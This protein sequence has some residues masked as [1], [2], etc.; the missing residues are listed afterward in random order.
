MSTVTALPL[1]GPTPHGA[2]SSRSAR[3]HNDPPAT[4]FAGPEN[5]L[6]VRAIT[7]LLEAAERGGEGLP[8][9]WSPVAL[10]G[11]SGSGKSALAQSVFQAWSQSEGGK[12][13]EHTLSLTAVD[14]RRRLDEAIGASA[15]SEQSIADF[16]S[17][18]RGLRLLV[19]EDLHRLTPKTHILQELVATLDALDQSGG[20][21]LAT[22]LRPLTEIAGLPHSLIS[23]FAGG[24]T[25]DIAP[26]AL[27]ARTE[28]LRESAQQTGCQ[29][30]P[31]AAVELA[32]SIPGDARRVTQVAELLRERFGARRK[33]GRRQ[34]RAFLE[35]QQRPGSPA[36]RDIT[37]TVARYY[38]L[39]V[40]NM[41][42]SSRKQ[43]VVLARAVAI[44]LARELTP[45]SYEDIGRYFGGRDHT[46]I[47][48]N[49]SRISS[50]L[51]KDRAL[52]S[53]IEELR[54]AISGQEK[55]KQ[56]GA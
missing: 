20:L 47:M 29:I 48:H 19:L 16:R 13:A 14:F 17:R 39:S 12:H 51:A 44:F 2:G 53:A 28:L 27:E 40:R 41:R 37:T 30:E 25:I 21:L 10:I 46:T 5:R 50:R 26:P 18:M 45:L 6:A 36:L 15:S 1:P 35:E 43:S 11:P 34:A 24:L 32:D 22:S 9:S 56:T 31:A 49:H 7:R 42:S 55:G 23:R 52:R 4:Y 38:S 54:T 33:I 8:E 3:R